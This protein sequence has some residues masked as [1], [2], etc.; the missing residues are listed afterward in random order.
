MAAEDEKDDGKP[1][2]DQPVK[3]VLKDGISLAKEMKKGTMKY[4][5]KAQNVHFIKNLVKGKVEERIYREAVSSLYF[6]YR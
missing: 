5:R 4:H 1:E 3:T 2:S 6:L